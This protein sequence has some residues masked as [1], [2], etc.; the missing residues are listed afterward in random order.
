MIKTLQQ[1]NGKISYTTKDLVISDIQNLQ[2]T[3]NKNANLITKVGETVD[4]MNNTLSTLYSDISDCF[5]FDDN[6]LKRQKTID[7]I[8]F[9]DTIKVCFHLMKNL[10]S[11]FNPMGSINM[12]ESHD[13]ALPVMD[14]KF[15]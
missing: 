3:L 2:S 14:K 7:E 9:E 10:D 4:G 8:D 6:G 1:N 11:M 12:Y 5:Y 13:E 15:Y